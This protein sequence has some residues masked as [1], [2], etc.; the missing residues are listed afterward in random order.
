MSTFETIIQQ[1][2]EKHSEINREQIL[3]RLSVARNMTGGLIADDS[4]LR[5]IAAEMGLE[6]PNENG[7]FKPKLSLGHLVAGL[8]NATVTGRIVAVYPVKIFEGAKPGKLG[9]VI[10]VDNDGV[11]RVIL[12]NEKANLI[13]QGELQAGQIVKFAHGYT[14]ADRFGTP[15]LHIG[16][17]SQV[18]LNPQN[19][20]PEDYPFISKFTVKINE[21]TMEQKSVNIEAKVKEVYAVSTFTRGDQSTGK[22]QRVKVGDETGE[23]VVVFWNEKAEEAIAKLRKGAQ[24]QIVNGKVKSSQQ[25]G[26]VEVHVDSATYT[27]VSE[28]LMKALKIVDLTENS[29]DVCVE[30]EVATIPVSKEVKTSK[31]EMVKLTSFDLKDE[32]GVVRVTAWRE[33]AEPASKLIFGEK[34]VLENVYAKMG[35][36]GKVELSTR[37]ASTI[38]KA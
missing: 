3:T 14:K 16:E 20:K 9:S 17:R 23:V 34:V 35:Y 36:N 8:N 21:I 12:W 2:L 13:E 4:L 31:G 6:I 32:T 1:I 29:G 38:T 30:G 11:L 28:M 5:M 27:N 15:E 18:E 22:V 33:Q 25:I 37:A 26:E 10:I 19:A 7:T 24:I